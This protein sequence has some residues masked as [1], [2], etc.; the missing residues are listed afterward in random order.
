MDILDDDFDDVKNYLRSACKDL[1]T[2]NVCWIHGADGGD[3]WCRSCCYFKV[4]HL[5]RHDKKNRRDYCVDGGW[6]TEE[7][8]PRFCKGCGK[9]LDVSLTTFAVESELDHFLS[10]G[11][12]GGWRVEW[13]PI[14]QVTAFEML[15]VFEA[16]DYEDNEKIKADLHSLAEKVRECAM[17]ED[18]GR[19]MQ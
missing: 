7:D 14:R 11:W 13:G 17:W 1:D 15:N 5:R 9:P 10:G 3:C 16:G 2:E 8:G 19:L 6:G 18:G 12:C 4:R